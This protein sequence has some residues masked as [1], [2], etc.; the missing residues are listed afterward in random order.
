M[1]RLTAIL[2]A[3]DLLCSV[4]D[5]LPLTPDELSALFVVLR[6]VSALDRNT[7]TA[8]HCREARPRL[9]ASAAGSD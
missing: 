2:A 6:L 7:D 4:P 9:A 1:D 8:D 5:K 3:M